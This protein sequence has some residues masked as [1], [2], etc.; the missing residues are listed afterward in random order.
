MKLVVLGLLLLSQLGSASEFE[1][2]L[3]GGKPAGKGAENTIKHRCIDCRN[4]ESA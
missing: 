2:T 4:Q 3:I 1:H